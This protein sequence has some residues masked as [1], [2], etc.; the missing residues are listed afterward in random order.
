[1]LC[2][3]PSS[4][5]SSTFAADTADQNTD[6]RRIGER[7]REIEEEK[8]GQPNAKEE[9]VFVVVV[10]VVVVVMFFPFFL[11]FLHFC[12]RPS[13][14]KQ[15]RDAFDPPPLSNIMIK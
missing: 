5:S 12:G 1:L 11:S 15:T 10:V 3:S 4:V 14:Q 8:E 13:R 7:R 9:L 6:T 2:F